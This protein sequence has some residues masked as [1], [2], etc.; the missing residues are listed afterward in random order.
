MI[1]L[2]R[3]DP[4]RLGARSVSSASLMFFSMASDYMVLNIFQSVVR[5]S[6]AAGGFFVFLL[7]AVPCLVKK[8]R[9]DL[10]ESPQDERAIQEIV[11]ARHNS[12]IVE[13]CN[14]AFVL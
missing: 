11:Q 12:L 13:F 5:R 14:A 8:R 10:V 2:T 6:G 1:L 4:G 3:S 9:K 7:F